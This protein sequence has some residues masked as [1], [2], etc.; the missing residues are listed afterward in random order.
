MHRRLT[1]YSSSMVIKKTQGC[2]DENVSFHRKEK[3]ECYS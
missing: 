1:I 2:T 3:D